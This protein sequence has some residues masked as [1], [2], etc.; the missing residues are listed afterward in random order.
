MNEKTKGLNFA[1][2]IL[3]WVKYFLYG[4][5]EIYSKNVDFNKLFKIFSKF[6]THTFTVIVQEF[7]EAILKI[8]SAYPGSVSLS[9]HKNQLVLGID[10]HKFR[11]FFSL[12]SPINEQIYQ[13]IEKGTSFIKGLVKT[14]K[15]ND[16]IF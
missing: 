15:L 13:K 10:K 11:F 6:D 1:G 12:K 4:F 16:S 8:K 9:F 7:I 3:L 2:D 5:N 14:L